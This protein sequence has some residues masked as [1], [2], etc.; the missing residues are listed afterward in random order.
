MTRWKTANIYW[1]GVMIRQTARKVMCDGAS[2]S[3]Q[4]VGTG[5]NWNSVKNT[6]RRATGMS[7]PMEKNDPNRNE[8]HQNRTQKNRTRN[9][10]GMITCLKRENSGDEWVLLLLLLMM[11]RIAAQRK[12][13]RKN[14]G[15]TTPFHRA[16]TLCIDYNRIASSREMRQ[17]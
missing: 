4:W 10:Y 2:M 7:R 9:T 12:N 5:Q 16:Q 13:F 8:P 1:R 3:G 15:K 14:A 6:R 11:K 17:M